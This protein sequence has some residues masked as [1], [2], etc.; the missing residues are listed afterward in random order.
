MV[1]KLRGRII[2]NDGLQ[3]N[4]PAVVANTAGGVA[5]ESR[6]RPVRVAR[7]TLTDV[8]V[9]ILAAN[10][11]GSVKLCDL[12]AGTTAIFGVDLDL[13]VTGSAVI[14]DVTVLDYAV[15]TVA[16]TSID[17]SNAGEDN[18]VA[19]GDVAALGVIDARTT[20]ALTPPIYIDKGTNAIYLN[21]QAAIGTN[22][23]VT[24][25]G[26]VDILYMEIGT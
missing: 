20:A 16:L 12:P 10:D 1:N 18:L 21:L 15:G 7:L 4:G 2:L 13:V 11:Y 22:T 3:D 17:F 8:A 23:T 14:T 5:I 9:A 24:V 6:L 25:D 26:T 19:E